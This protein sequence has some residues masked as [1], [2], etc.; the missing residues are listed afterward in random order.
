VAPTNDSW[1]LLPG[2]RAAIVDRGSGP[3][4][5]LSGLSR[6]APGPT[7]EPAAFAF[8]TKL[9]ARGGRRLRV[10]IAQFSQLS[11]L[12]DLRQIQAMQI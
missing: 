1:R 10:V 6:I 9:L 11:G 4:L 12:R 5:N 3:R 7:I 8:H 2:G